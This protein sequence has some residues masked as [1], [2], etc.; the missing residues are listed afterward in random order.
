VGDLRR[1]FVRILEGFGRFWKLWYF[2]LWLVDVMR[3]I[4]SYYVLPD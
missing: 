3:V 2:R 1:G 4:M